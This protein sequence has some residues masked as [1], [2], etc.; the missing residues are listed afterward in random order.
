MTRDAHHLLPPRRPAAPESATPR[1]GFT[2]IEL[3]VSM[4][5]LLLAIITVAT[6]FNISSDAAGRT[7]AHVQLLEAS[8]AVHGELNDKL[9]HIVPGL[10]IIESPPPTLARAESR[11]GP[12]YFRLRHD[13]L[14]FLASHGG[15]GAFESFTDPTRGTP[16]VPTR[17][18]ATSTEALVYFGPGIPVE[19]NATVSGRALPFDDETIGLTAS[20]W[21]FMHR[22]ILLLSGFLP[23]EHPDWNAPS[24]PPTMSQV[25]GAGG[26]LDGGTLENNY[27]NFREGRMDAVIS[28]TAPGGMDATSAALISF[29]NTLT[30]TN[31]G[32]QTLFHGDEST[33]RARALWEPGLTPVTA[34][35]A[36]ALHA[37]FFTRSGWTFMPRLADFRIE[38]TDGGRVDP[39]G[40]DNIAATGDEDFRTRW[41]GLAPA[42]LS[43]DAANV[44]NLSNPNGLRYQARLRGLAVAQNPSNPNPGNPDNDPAATNAFASRI[45]WAD[46]RGATPHVQA[47]YRAVWRG[48]D[49]DQYRPRALRFT[50]RIY[51]ANKRLQRPTALDLNEDGI[52]DPGTPAMPAAEPY[53]V[54]RH[55]QEF[56]VVVALP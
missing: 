38:W 14:V 37:D 18:P 5:V 45:E 32:F 35:Y 47:R 9:S 28:D 23:A 3:T 54:S 50:Y 17:A 39:L 4:G 36:N 49:Y 31:A 25:F 55:G 44:P 15:E 1:P 33:A 42:P 2:L 34:S 27:L 22:A 8:A 40:P 48:N 13:R 29:I 6:I 16:A 56:S 46:G 10:L 12:R 19:G 43:V 52:L 26:M 7:A 24:G 51:D 11:E 41:F 21:V 30:V 20:E 53:I